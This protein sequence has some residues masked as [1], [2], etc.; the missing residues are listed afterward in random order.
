MGDCFLDDTVVFESL[1]RVIFFGF[2]YYY[3]IGKEEVLKKRR[4]KCTA[5]ID[6][7]ELLA[8]FDPL[9]TVDFLFIKQ[10]CRA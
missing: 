3:F 10:S 4:A 2:S 7:T 9:G 5:C 8:I 1:R 6:L